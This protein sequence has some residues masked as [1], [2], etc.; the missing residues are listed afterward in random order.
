VKVGAC[1]SSLG[2]CGERI[3]GVKDA[4]TFHVYDE[5][6]FD[7]LDTMIEEFKC[8]RMSSWGKEEPCQN[9]RESRIERWRKQ[10]EPAAGKV[11]KK[12]KVDWHYSDPEKPG[13]NA[14]IESFNG[15]LRDE[16]LNETLFT[17]LMQAR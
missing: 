12:T 1:P 14:F 5:A 17:S 8:E 13:Q 10:D 2:A 4:S 6:F 11:G 15:R 16:F 7:K 3:A 9:R